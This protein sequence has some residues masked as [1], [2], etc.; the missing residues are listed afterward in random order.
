MVTGLR[1]SVCLTLQV[2]TLEDEMRKLSDPKER[3]GL[4]KV[5]LGLA[6]GAGALGLA[7]CGEPD[8]GAPPA[9]GDTGGAPAAP[10]TE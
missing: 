4:K 5:V 3:K 8:N 2:A 10:P 1:I 9:P 6:L 7:A